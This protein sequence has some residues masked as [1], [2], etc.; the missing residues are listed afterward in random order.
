MIKQVPGFWSK[1]LQA[2][3]VPGVIESCIHACD[4]PVFDSLTAIEVLRFEVDDNP[5]RGD[6]RSFKITFEFD[7]NRFFTVRTL[8]KTFWHRRTEEGWTG[9]VS[10]PVEINYSRTP[11]GDVL[12]GC[13]ADLESFFAFFGYRGRDVTQEESAKYA[14]DY[15]KSKNGSSKI[16][17]PETKQDGS[18]QD[19]ESILQRIGSPDD[20]DD[21]PCDH[22]TFPLGEDIAIAISEDLYPG[23]LKYFGIL[24][25][26]SSNQ[27]ADVLVAHASEQDI[28]E[29]DDEDVDRSDDDELEVSLE[30][31]EH[32][33]KR[34][35]KV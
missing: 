18:E 27:G 29:P 28:S 13:A 5:E 21:D 11:E 31:D 32:P 1:V 35:R 10:E 19:L 16:S 23:A 33:P 6:P 3:D 15:S 22:E 14:E 30:V 9:L 26:P 20:N 12:A 8:E 4:I 7:P 17:T 34:K 24:P 2:D 25:K